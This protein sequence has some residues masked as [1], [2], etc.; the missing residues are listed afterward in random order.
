MNTFADPKLLAQLLQ[1][2]NPTDLIWTGNHQV[3]I[4]R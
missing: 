3:K 2:R 4:A 1:L